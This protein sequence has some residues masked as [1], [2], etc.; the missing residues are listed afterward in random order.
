MNRFLLA[1]VISLALACSSALAQNTS[2]AQTQAPTAASPQASPHTTQ[3]QAQAP[4]AEQ[5][6]GSTRIAPG[7]VIPVQLTKTIDAKKAK[8]GE[9]VVAKVTQDMKTQNGEVL[10][11]K[12]SE[13]IGHVTEAQPRNKQQKESEL[14]INFDQAVIGGSSLSLPMSIQAVIGQQNNN[15]SNPGTASGG[16]YPPAPSPGAGGGMPA[17]SS[18]PGGMGGAPPAQPSPSAGGTPPPDQNA[19]PSRPAING[20]T[21]GVIG[22]S[23]LTLAPAQNANQGS[24][25]TSEKH[26]VKLESGTMLLLKVRPR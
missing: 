21:E 22:I 20:H 19:P 1:T 25:M 14:A 17:G 5:H 2:A 10:V 12:D 23:N 8:T 16:N 9:Q 4:A 6:S 11:P 7:S 3:P 26:N 24:V 18:S 13:I 15:N